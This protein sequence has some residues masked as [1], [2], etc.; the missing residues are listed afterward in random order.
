MIEC[1]V[2]GRSFRD[3]AKSF[4]VCDSTMQG[5]KRRLAVKILAFMGEDILILVQRLPRWKD[6]IMNCRERLACKYD[7]RH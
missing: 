3:A 5:D 4:R 7:R 2:E 6:D 1:L